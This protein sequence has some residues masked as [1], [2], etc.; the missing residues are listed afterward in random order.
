VGYT[1]TSYR[2]RLAMAAM[3]T[4]AASGGII[5]HYAANP[6]TLRDIGTLLLVLWLPAVGN[7]IAF[8]IGKI[9]RSVPPATDFAEHSPFEPQLQVRLEATGSPDE[10][11]EQAG[12]QGQRCTVL[13][14]R[15]GF[16]ARSGQPLAV[17]LAPTGP[18]TVLLQLLH[19][20]V[21]L[22]H[23]PAGT[24]FHLLVG[25]TAIAKGS[26]TRVT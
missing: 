6:S 8:F 22:R 2:R 20:K 16:T 15:R 12:L 21:A 7:L 3:L 5:R 26:V 25:S 24:T 19:P 10:L 14:G 4:L 17:L 13:V 1:V 9:P 11:L 18:Q 23:L